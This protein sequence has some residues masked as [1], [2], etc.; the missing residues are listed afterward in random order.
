MA[1]VDWIGVKHPI[2]GVVY[3]PL[4]RTRQYVAAGELPRTTLTE[5]L[6]DSFAR[7][8]HRIA[9]GT[10]EG[11]VTY[12]AFDDITNRFAAA[13]GR[14]GLQPHDR[15]LFQ[16]GNSKELV[17]AFVG[18]LKAGLIP[19]CTLPAHRE[20]EIGYLGCHVDARLHIVHGDDPKFDLE[21]FALGMRSRIPTMRHIVSVR[22]TVRDG[23]SRFEDLIAREN[24]VEAAAYV[25]AQ[26]RDPFQVA[27]FQL[28]G[29]TTGVPKVIPRMQNDYLLNA[30]HTIRILG[31]RE[32][33]VFFMPMPLI[34]NAAMICSLI[35]SLLTGS[36]F[37]IAADMSPEAWGKVFTTYKPTVV[38][39]IRALM[40]RLREV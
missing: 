4:E 34:H 14:L 13:L 37:T 30:Q 23:V 24:S 2:P 33:D 31:Y 28:S 32:T 11:D 22:G 38:C 12:A 25:R 1:N 10:P 26:A 15:V 21:G 40:P 16:T 17:F 19:V 9:L 35:P 5:A 39:L 18:C 6:C 27:V 36:L 20:L 29:G 7:H 3:P 8:A